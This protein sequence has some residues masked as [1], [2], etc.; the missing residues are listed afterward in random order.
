[1]PVA[2]NLVFVAR[3]PGVAAYTH[4]PRAHLVEVIWHPATLALHA[5]GA[6]ET[7]AD[8]VIV[9][10][11]RTKRKFVCFAEN[12]AMF[13][14]F[15]RVAILDDDLSLEKGATWDDVF[16]AM[17]RTPLVLAQPALTE[18][19]TNVWPVTHV[20]R[21]CFYR[22]T[23]FVE[24][25]APIFT[26]RALALCVQFFL[27]DRN[28]WGLEA[29][30]SS[31]LSP[32]GILDAVPMIHTR[33]V[34]SA[35]S[36]TGLAVHPETQAEAFRQKHKVKIPRGQT[37]GRFDALGAELGPRPGQ[38]IFRDCLRAPDRFSPLCAYHRTGNTLAD[39]W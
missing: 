6:L 33:P 15:D 21:G 5:R 3:G 8:A 1:M 7:Y 26:R 11:D 17:A 34:G 25:M 2:R 16:E 20:D 30:W 12:Y 19:S 18:A 37:C 23:D 27:E 29:L 32:I 13:A 36:L 4:P 14:G 28:G 39:L 35:H 31:R 10:P 22:R 24:V 38:C 9:D